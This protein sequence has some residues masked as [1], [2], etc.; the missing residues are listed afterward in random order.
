L[1]FGSTA[2]SMTGSGNSM[3]SR[4]TGFSGSQSVS[5]VVVSFRPAIATMSPAYA[6]SMS[7]RRVGVHLHHAADSRFSFTVFSRDTPL[8]R[9]PE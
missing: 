8:F 3:R 1:V 5:P 2:I 6:T 7:S 9:T 4:M